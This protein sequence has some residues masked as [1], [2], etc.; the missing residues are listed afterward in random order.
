MIWISLLIYALVVGLL[1]QIPSWM[2]R[3]YRGVTWRRVTR[4]K[5]VYLTFDDGPIPDVT[6]AILD[7]LARYG[8]KA[9]FFVVG[10]N[11]TKYPRVYA[12]MLAEG[13]RVGNHTMHHTKGSRCSLDEYLRDVDACAQVMAANSPKPLA[14]Q[15]SSPL[16]RPPY[17]KMT[18]RQ[19]RAVL[20][21][22]YEIILW[23]VLTHDY[24]KRY[25]P[26]KMLKIVKR[27][28]RIGSI[29]NF[30][31]SVKSG[32]RTIEVLPQVIEWLQSE[33]YRIE[34]L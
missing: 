8:V 32:A 17:G 30:H 29:I 34:L 12:R 3:L 10:D 14:G 25:T 1:Y 2:Q 33:G 20:D 4:D 23:D 31:D 7:V 6:P 15:G 26:E 16:F 5:C 19:K 27:Y 11:I 24:S 28:T 21:R 13:H 9:T 18:G 22:G